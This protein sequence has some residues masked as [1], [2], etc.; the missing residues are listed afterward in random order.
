[1]R[2]HRTLFPHLCVLTFSIL[3]ACGMSLYRPLAAK[4][5]ATALKEETIVQLNAGEYS[6]AEQTAAKLW[7][8]EKT[9]D[10]ASLYAIALASTAGIGL[11]DLTVKA[12]KQQSDASAQSSDI[13]NTL[14]EI[15]PEFDDDQLSKIQQSLEILDSAPEKNS[16]R[17]IFQRCLTA[18]IYTLPTITTLQQKIT[19]AQT[20]LSSLPSKLGS[21]A[22]ASCSASATSI[23]AAAVEVNDLITQLSGIADQFKTAI[24]VIGDC[25]PKS[26]NTSDIN[27]VSEQVN[28]LT[29]A[30]DK[31]CSVPQNQKIGPYTIPSCLNDTINAAGANEA[32]AGDGEVAG[33]ELFLNCSGGQ[34]F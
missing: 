12:I 22:G 2:A 26:G 10:T 11:F 21:G 33:C 15:L 31:G 17:I 8:I 4:E 27:I 25:F 23:N 18:A 19:R 9:N 30:A 16:G 14:S 13:F 32:V 7:S 3:T 28:K 29:Q 1:M 20:T 5:S 6:E 24:S 34:C